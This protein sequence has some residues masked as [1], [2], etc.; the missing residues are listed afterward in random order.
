MALPTSYFPDLAFPTPQELG[1]VLDTDG[2]F[3]QI[4]DAVITS[5]Y[6]GAGTVSIIGT[7][8][9]TTWP[10]YGYVYNNDRTE[11][12]LYVSKT[13][14][15][16]IEVLATGR[17]LLGTT[18]TAGQIGDTLKFRE[19]RVL[20]G[21]INRMLVELKAMQ[22]SLNKIVELSATA[23]IDVRNSG[24][25]HSN[26]NATGATN[27]R[28]ATLPSINTYNERLRYPILIE[29]AN[30]LRIKANTL[31]YIRV[32]G[33]KSVINGYIESVDVGASILL[34]PASQNNWVG[35]FRGGAWNVDGA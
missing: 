6:A 15:D 1:T 24:K 14:N 7:G 10:E 30:G 32:E 18:P 2:S 35:M 28:I 26:V 11:L 27:T 17:G 21:T 5:T 29:N 12:M 25:I 20:G 34:V 16:Q 13:S 8:Q 33:T 3:S 31:D 4:A 9:F 19:S 22:E 23:S